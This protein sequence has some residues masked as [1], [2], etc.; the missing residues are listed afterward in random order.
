MRIKK[1][2]EFVKDILIIRLFNKI[3]I[4]CKM[5]HKKSMKTFKKIEL[6]KENETTLFLCLLM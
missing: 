2:N 1:L 4:Y 6:H 3:I 5:F